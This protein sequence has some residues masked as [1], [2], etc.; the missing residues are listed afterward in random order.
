[1]GQEERA[2]REE[3]RF[4]VPPFPWGFESEEEHYKRRR[5]ENRRTRMRTARG[6]DIFTQTWTPTDRE[7]T[8]LI[9]MVHGYGNNTSWTFQNTAM[10][11]TDMGYAACASDL[12]GHGRTQGL[13]GF[14]PDVQGAADDCREFFQRERERP[15][16]RRI[17][18]FLY[19]ES[20][21]GA[22]CLLIHFR[23]PD[24]WDGAILAAAMCKISDGMRPPWPVADVLACVAHVFPTWAIVPSKDLVD[25]SVS[26]PYKRELARRNPGRYAGRPRLGTVVELLRVTALLGH[27]L[28]DV[29]LP[30]LI[31][32]GDR[33]V[34]TE[35]ATSVA[36]FERA[37]SADKTLKMYAGMRHSL[38]QGEPDAN[39]A[40]LLADIS[41][42]LRLRVQRWT[43]P[44]S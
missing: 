35:P 28:Q 26:N 43:P 19:G 22:I 29:D 41:A 44:T 12:E 34:V 16:F 4:E 38:L 27:R 2:L 23:E 21:G 6:V 8:A 31:I 13:K 5:V 9:C 37:R 18:A 32:H 14:L 40:I 24:Q 36:L 42:W 17:P 1:M 39:V 3:G 33:D 20:L 25:K 30:V 10:L 11:F 15:E 7:P